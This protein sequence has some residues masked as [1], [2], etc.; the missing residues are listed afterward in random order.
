MITLGNTII[1]QYANSPAML[2][3]LGSANAAIS[4]DAD[5]Q[6]IYD[7]IL[8]INTAVGYGLDILGRIVGISRLVTLPANTNFVG[9][10]EASSW[11]P[12]GQAPWWDGNISELGVSTVQALNDT[13][14]RRVVLAKALANISNCSALSI[15]TILRVLFGATAAQYAYVQDLG[16]MSMVIQFLDNIS[17]YNMYILTQ[18]AIIPKPAGVQ[19]SIWTPSTGLVPIGSIIA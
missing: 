10:R 19:A 16:N 18:K 11:Q 14:F 12:W 3:I 4:P 17:D 7:S 15:N 9:W 8:N 13:V 6:L 5:L 2:A 1:S